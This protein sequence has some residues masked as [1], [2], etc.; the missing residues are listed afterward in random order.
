M[1]S[2]DV[3]K[4][5]TAIVYLQR[6]ADGNNP[7]NNMPSDEDSVL[8]NPNVIRCMFFV[9][10]ILE[11]VKR[12][13]GYIGQKPKKSER[14]SVSA[15]TL[16]EF[17]YKED[18]PISK[19]VEQMNECVDLEV[20]KKLNYQVI[21]KWLRLNDFLKEEHNQEFNKTVTLPTEKGIQLGIY[22]EKRRSSGGRDYMVV[23]YGMQA[24]EYIVQNVEKILCSEVV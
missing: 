24:Q 22:A 14:L 23:I 15:E 11:E 1:E 18:K 16:A 10:E 2:V 3:K 20:Y 4:L 21:T 17:S 13:N 6:I 5:E 19:F 9:K 8:N 7:I 12:N